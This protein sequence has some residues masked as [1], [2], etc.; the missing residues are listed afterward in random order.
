MDEILYVIQCR[1]VKYTSQF[2]TGACVLNDEFSQVL[3]GIWAEI[4]K[5][6]RD[7]EFSDVIMEYTIGVRPQRGR[8]WFKCTKFY[9]LVNVRGKNHWILV[10]VELLT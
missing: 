1:I 3:R 7:Y 2:A 8:D 5:S 4:G 10:V 9:I 6:P